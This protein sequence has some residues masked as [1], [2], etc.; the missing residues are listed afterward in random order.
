MGIMGH[1]GLRSCILKSTLSLSKTALPLM[2]H[3]NQVITLF[4]LNLDFQTGLQDP[5][6]GR[7]RMT[8]ENQKL[9]LDIPFKQKFTIM[10]RLSLDIRTY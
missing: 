10:T 9:R 8:Q 2:D 3:Y 4:L 1:T 5:A 7:I 6:N